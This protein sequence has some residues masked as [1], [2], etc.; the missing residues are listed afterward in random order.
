Q[1]FPQKAVDISL[2]EEALLPSILLS[3]VIHP[4][5]QPFA[6]YAKTLRGP[7]P[8]EV[9][10][11]NEGGA[12]MNP[13]LKGESAETYQ[14]GF[15]SKASNLLFKDDAFFFKAS[16]FNSE[17]D[18]YIFSQSFTLC[19][20]RIKCLASDALK[21]NLAFNENFNMNVYIN[22]LTTVHNRGF[23]L[24][25]NYDAGFAYARFS[26]SHEKTDQ[27]TSIASGVFGAD[28]IN[29]LPSTFYNLD[30]GVRLLDKK[31]IIGSI[32]KYTGANKKISTEHYLNE[33]TGNLEKE[34]NAKNP[35]IIDLYSSYQVNKNISLRFTVQNLMNR[36]Y[37]EALNRLNSNPSQSSSESPANTAR[38]RTYLVG[39][40]FRM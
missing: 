3:A 12:S 39:A 37:S 2:K 7:N 40:E 10:F 29:D 19:N 4:W 38:G 21:N 24:E 11:S 23:E 32:F 6:S 13:Y 26:F 28:D 5:F 35:V 33:E 18:N 9:F 31:M 27:P 17:I 14:L 22:S 1:C 8:Q 16:Y 34:T 20:N 36:D 25:A 30:T 15:N